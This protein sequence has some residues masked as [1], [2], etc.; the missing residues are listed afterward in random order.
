MLT[1]LRVADHPAAIW[2]QAAGPWLRAHGTRWQEKRVVLAPNAAW[3]A[4]LK[5]RAVAEKIPVLGI[6]WLTPGHLRTR[7]LR[8]LPGPALRVA[9]R[10]D[11]HLLLEVAAASLPDNP[12]A[13]AFGPD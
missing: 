7:L 4:A 5:E 9:L 1:R 2:G 13:R 6:D 3:I 8:A 11:L 12:L 10:E